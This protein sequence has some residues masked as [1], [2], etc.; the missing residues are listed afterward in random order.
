MSPERGSGVHRYAIVVIGHEEPVK[1]AIELSRN[2]FDLH[3]YLET[4]KGTVQGVS[5]FRSLW[6]KHVDEIRPNGRIFG[7]VQE[8]YRGPAICKFTVH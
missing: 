4:T 8:E 7:Q 3:S 6:T 1:V 5:F 2:N